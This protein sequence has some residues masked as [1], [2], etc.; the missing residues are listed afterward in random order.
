MTYYVFKTFKIY[1]VLL[2]CV[3]FAL[4][5]NACSWLKMDLDM[6]RSH[7]LLSAMEGL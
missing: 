3:D 6:I 4:A 5:D 2:Q 1:H 7:H